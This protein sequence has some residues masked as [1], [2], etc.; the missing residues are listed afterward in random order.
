VLAE[1]AQ[2]RQNR[3]AML[4]A[5]GK[6]FGGIADFSKIQAGE[7]PQAPQQAQAKA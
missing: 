3:V 1:D 2:V 4:T 6:L 7:Q 5:I